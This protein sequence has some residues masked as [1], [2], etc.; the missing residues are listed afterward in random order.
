M[1]KFACDDQ[2]DALCGTDETKPIVLGNNDGSVTATKK[3]STSVAVC[4][5]DATEYWV[6]IGNK[7][8]TGVQKAS[9][10]ARDKC[11]MS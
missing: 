6:V 11:S 5:N 2:A 9:A 1:V 7:G 4:T 10:A 3:I 8:K